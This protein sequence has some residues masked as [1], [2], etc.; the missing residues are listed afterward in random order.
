MSG[1]GVYEGRLRVSVVICTYSSDRWNDL[2]TA[3]DSARFQD[4]APPYEVVV[5]V[6][7]NSALFDRVRGE[8]DGIISVENRVDP[9]LRGA[10]NAGVQASTGDVVAF[11]DDDAIAPPDWIER[12]VA[13]YED[14]TVIAVGGAAEMLLA[15]SS[16]PA[17]LP[18]EFLWTVGCTYKG[19]PEEQARIRNLMGCNM[20]FRREAFE[21]AGMFRLGYSCDET[22]FCIRLA[23]TVPD[24]ILLFDPGIVVRHRVSAARMTWRYFLSRCY[25]EGGSKAVVT[26]LLGSGDGLSSERA[27]TLRVLPRGVMEGMRDAVI[28]Q[29]PSSAARSAAIVAG[30]ATTTV[31]Y[32]VARFSTAS[33]ARQRGWT[34][35]ADVALA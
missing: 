26:W 5:V 22:E 27:Y 13:A 10:R 33:V 23:Q 6:D 19:M 29:R 7:N 34:G 1:S 11:L 17:W 21:V 32:V 4:R 35:S 25:F 8:V 18:D 28:H 20:S 30:L 12:L 9:G 24:R 15:G 14:N 16:R 3:V 2:K 31:G